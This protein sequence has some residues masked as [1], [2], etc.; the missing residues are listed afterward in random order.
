MNRHAQIDIQQFIRTALDWPGCQHGW[1][2]VRVVV[3]LAGV[4]AWSMPT[5]RQIHAEYLRNS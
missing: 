3:A 1:H 4:I 5:W 2:A